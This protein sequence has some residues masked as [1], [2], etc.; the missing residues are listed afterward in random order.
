MTD[1]R[2][3]GHRLAAAG[4]T[5]QAL[6]AWA[7]TH[8][9]ALVPQVLPALAARPVVPAATALALF[10]A[11]ATLPVDAAARLPLDALLAHGLVER[12]GDRVR[13]AVAILPLGRCLLVCD[14]ADAVDHPELVC[15]PDDSSYHLAGA[16]PAERVARWLDLGAGSAFAALARPE[17]AAAIVG[18]DVNPRAVRYA[19][20]G[21]ALSGVGHVALAQGDLSEA[22]ADA[23]ELVTCNAPIP[24]EED[25]RHVHVDA[26]ERAVWRRTERTLFARLWPA[27]RGRLAPGGQVIVH[28]A[29][30]ALPAEL[31]GEVAIVVYTPPGTR[32]FAVQWW[33]P[34]APAR[35]A[36]GY[37][38]LTA[39]RPH[40]EAR[41]R[42][43]LLAGALPPLE[44]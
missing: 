27:A 3:L 38:A 34:D 8:R 24:D 36:V 2:G 30:D 39:A 4:L 26:I 28:A 29:V 13:A 33:T 1:L 22:P 40:L 35:R 37:R 25:L 17:H 19:R 23:V 18:V 21:V 9:L 12:A 42:T 11:G 15:W 43:D 32:A 14:R 16:L 5:E 44:D 7:G 41:D 31:P 6:L 20:L 10:V